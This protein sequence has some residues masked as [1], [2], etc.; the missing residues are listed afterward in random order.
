MK[1][2]LTFAYCM[3]MGYAFP[4]VKIKRFRVW[5]CPTWRLGYQYSEGHF[6][7]FLVPPIGLGFVG[8]FE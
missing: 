4:L 6:M 3:R 2:H 5:F 1:S 7:L 8:E